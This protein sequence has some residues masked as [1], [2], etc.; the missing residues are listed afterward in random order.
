VLELPPV[1]AAS[2][3]LTAAAAADATLLVL[4]A[5]RSR[6]ADC[7]RALRLLRAAGARLICALAENAAD[8]A[9]HGGAFVFDAP[10]TSRPQ[11]WAPSAYPYRMER[12][13][14][15]LAA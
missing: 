1:I 10:S 4:C 15:P 3:S 14:N 9:L 7:S 5:S 13:R 11:R 2:E 6:P 8:A 12:R